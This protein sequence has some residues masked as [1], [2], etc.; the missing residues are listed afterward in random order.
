MKTRKPAGTPAL[1]G[2]L[3]LVLLVGAACGGG[4]PAGSARIGDVQVTNATARATTD[5]V[6]ALY[7]TVDNGGQEADALVSASS[8]SATMVHLMSTAMEGMSMQMREVARIEVPAGGRVEL[9]PGGYHVMLMG[10]A[11]PLKVGERI[12]LTLKFERAGTV[13]LRVPVVSYSGGQ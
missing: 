9:A 3:S 7:F 12:E 10:V 8:D 13:R 5:D 6:S 2:L 1:A 4:T 11:R